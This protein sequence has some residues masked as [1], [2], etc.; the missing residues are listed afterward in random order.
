MLW[1]GS[2]GVVRAQI[3]AVKNHEVVS[4]EEAE[5][6]YRDMLE[7]KYVGMFSEEELDILNTAKNEKYLTEYEQEIFFYMNFARIFP[8]QFAELFV[9]DFEGVYGYMKSY[10]FDERKASLLQELSNN[11]A[12][13]VVVPSESL[14][15][16]AECFAM[17]QGT[18]GRVGHS[19]GR[20]KC[21]SDFDA[22]CCGYGDYPNGLYT[23]LQ[24][25]ID[26]GE[27]NEDLGHRRILLSE[28]M[29]S[30]GCAV[31]AH[32]RYAKVAVLDFGR[33]EKGWGKKRR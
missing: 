3:W 18:D 25:L 31:R 7:A 6:Y 17:A 23:V 13:G 19:R 20:Y 14:F 16:T 33:D 12:R 27:G 29:K 4:R 8:A 28:A 30:M 26:A 10:A 22:E 9:K 32:K 2:M 24:L 11:T 1:V 15:N 21:K 5:Q